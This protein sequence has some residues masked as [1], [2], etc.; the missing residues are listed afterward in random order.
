MTYHAHTRSRLAHAAWLIVALVA[1]IA[2]G[3]LPQTGAL[4]AVA[5]AIFFVA[6]LIQP[7]LALY[8]LVFSVPY[9]SLRQV[10][11]GGLAVSSTEVLVALLLAAWLARIAARWPVRPQDGEQPRSVPLLIPVLILLWAY[12]LSLLQAWDAT[13]ALKETA[14]WAEVA[15]VLLVT[16]HA[17]TDSRRVAVLLL[18]MFAA[19]WAQSL[20]GAYQFFRREGPESFAFGSYLRA[21]G[22]FGQP[23]ALG[24]Y[25]GLILPLALS[26]APRSSRSPSA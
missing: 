16:A 11:I 22:T 2:I 3:W 5:G 19:G 20:L 24:G 13:L 4:L 9:E 15:A 26:T 10:E 7:H 23:N 12:G 21:H 14:K 6:A 17:L 25:L 8:A 1:G 18:G